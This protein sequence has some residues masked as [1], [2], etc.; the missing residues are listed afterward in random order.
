[1]YLVK[2]NCALDHK[3][4]DTD[5]DGDGFEVST[6]GNSSG[7]QDD[8]KVQPTVNEK[9]NKSAGQI[10]AQKQL[11]NSATGM[12]MHGKGLTLCSR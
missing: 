12:G 2:N 6:F 4:K 5:E 7:H 3:Q 9:L 11:Q 1:M 10:E 8:Q